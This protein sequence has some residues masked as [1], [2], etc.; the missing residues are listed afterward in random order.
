M[1]F[2]RVQDQLEV[3]REI[4]KITYKWEKVHQNQKTH[5]IM[6]IRGGLK[7]LQQEENCKHRFENVFAL[8]VAPNRAKLTLMVAR[9]PMIFVLFCFV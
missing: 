9:K 5:M 1:Q 8:L 6:A 2:K 4:H 7:C 3:L